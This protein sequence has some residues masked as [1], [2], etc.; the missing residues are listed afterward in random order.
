MKRC[1]SYNILVASRRPETGI[2]GIRFHVSLAIGLCF[3][4]IASVAG[5]WKTLEM[6]FEC[7]YYQGLQVAETSRNKSVREDLEAVQRVVDRLQAKTLEW[8]A[9]DDRVRL[10]FDLKAVAQ[11]ERMLGVGGSSG[12]GPIDEQFD[13]LCRRS[14]YQAFQFRS[15]REA[16]RSKVRQWGYTPTVWPCAGRVTSDYGFRIHPV[17]GYGSIHEGTD[18]AAPSGTSV[19]ATAGGI[20][21][22]CERAGHY[23]NLI[24][25]RHGEDLRTYYGHLRRILVRE[26]QAV[27]RN[28]VV[29]HV[30]QTGMA[31]GPHLHYEVRRGKTPQNPDS[32]LLPTAYVVD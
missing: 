13:L 8:F 3:F 4:A 18:I 21:E 2:V 11:E 32:Y 15:V 5:T 14:E 25:I 20:V 27:K 26:G 29:G 17:A 19:R 10:V 16:L 31:T 12:P 7:L 9:Y 22:K 6:W 23:G 28:E 30:G 1:F 24:V